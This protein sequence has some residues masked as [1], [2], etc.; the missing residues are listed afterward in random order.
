MSTPIERVKAMQARQTGA[1]AQARADFPEFAAWVDS[2]RTTFGAKLTW[3]KL[4]NGHEQ[5]ER[6]EVRM[7]RILGRPVVLVEP[8]IWT[9]IKVKRA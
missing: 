7:A 3:I 6:F 9:H 4:P 5:G 1:L 8:K 2:Y